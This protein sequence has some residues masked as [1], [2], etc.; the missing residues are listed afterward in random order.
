MA[1]RGTGA[2]AGPAGADALS[3]AASDQSARGAE[4]ETVLGPGRHRSGDSLSFESGKNERAG[5]GAVGA[6]IRRQSARG[7]TM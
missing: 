4:R 2:E 7:A 1:G 5:G 6:E 3:P